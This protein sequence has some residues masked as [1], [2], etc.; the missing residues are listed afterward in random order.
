MRIAFLSLAGAAL[1]AAAAAQ[2]DGGDVVRTHNLDVKER[3]AHLERIDVTAEKPANPEA[4]ALDAELLA[5]LDEAERAEHDP[6]P[7]IR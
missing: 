2:A 1:M 7:E 3:L 6:Q 5:I 4:E